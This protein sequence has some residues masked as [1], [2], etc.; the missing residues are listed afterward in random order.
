MNKRRTDQLQFFRFGAIIWV[1]N[2]HALIHNIGD[3]IPDYNRWFSIGLSGVVFFFI[4]SGFISGYYSYEKDVTVTFSGIVSYVKQKLK[5]LYPLY[6][7]VTLYSI[8]FS[9]IPGLVATRSWTSLIYPLRLLIRHLLLM[10][11]WIKIFPGEYLT[12]SEVGWFL[13]TLLFMLILNVPLRAAATRIRKLKNSTVI[14]AAICIASAALSILWC[15]LMRDTYVEFTACTIPIS[16]LGEYVCGMA[17]GYTLYPIVGRLEDNKKN[18]IVFTILEVIAI[19]IWLMWGRLGYP[20]WA[21]RIANWFVPNIILL[22]IFTPGTGYVSSLLRLKPLKALGDVSFNFYLIH[23][24]VI[25]TYL[26]ATGYDPAV[27]ATKFSYIF[28]FGISLLISFLIHS[29]GSKKPSQR[30][31]ST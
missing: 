8:I 19:I 12:Y 31:S 14:F 27:T 1:F 10:Q 30:R 6:L 16:R 5:K 2:F 13:S 22:T 20:E 7:V 9:E 18:R 3:V 26:A 28:C 29:A 21:L 17:L 23:S 11:S 24:M 4:L 25:N 15:Y